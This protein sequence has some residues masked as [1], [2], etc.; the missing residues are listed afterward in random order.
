MKT[1]LAPLGRGAARYFYFD[2]HSMICR[3]APVYSDDA[4]VRN[5]TLKTHSARVVNSH[6]TGWREISPGTEGVGPRLTPGMSRLIDRLGLRSG[7]E[8][9]IHRPHRYI[10]VD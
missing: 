9:E 4:T 5:V 3:G 7:M 2:C 10:E 6:F 8:I 1:S